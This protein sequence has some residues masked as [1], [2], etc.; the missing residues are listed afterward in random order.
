MN[1]Y[2]LW[3]KRQFKIHIQK[4]SRTLYA[5]RNDLFYLNKHSI[6]MNSTLADISKNSRYQYSTIVVSNCNLIEIIQDGYCFLKKRN[7]TPLQYSFDIINPSVLNMSSLY[8]KDIRS[9]EMY[10]T[11]IISILNEK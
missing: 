8:M 5:I 6:K 10:Y 4:N 9:N 2:S 1:E 11:N 7:T 3:L